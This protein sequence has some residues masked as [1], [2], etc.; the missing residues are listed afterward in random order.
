MC[1]GGY[2]NLNREDDPENPTWYVECDIGSVC[3]YE[4]NR[5]KRRQLNCRC[6]AAKNPNEFVGVCPNNYD[7]HIFERYGEAVQNMTREGLNH[8]HVNNQFEFFADCY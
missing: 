1:S 6:V 4:N 5:G 3:I 8:C 7:M 2:H